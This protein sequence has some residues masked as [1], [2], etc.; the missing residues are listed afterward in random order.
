[1]NNPNEVVVNEFVIKPTTLVSARVEFKEPTGSTFPYEFSLTLEQLGFAP[2]APAIQKPATAD[3]EA[4]MIAGDK[5]KLQE[6]ADQFTRATA[7]ANADPMASLR[8][9]LVDHFTHGGVPNHPID[10]GVYQWVGGENALTV[11]SQEDDDKGTITGTPKAGYIRVTG[12]A[13]WGL[14]A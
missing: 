13:V 8:T 7:A 6:L 5:A 9:L 3:V 11:R 14:L 2:T 12:S 10:N 1:M 4:A